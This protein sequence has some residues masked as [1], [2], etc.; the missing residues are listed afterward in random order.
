MSDADLGA[1][2]RMLAAPVIGAAAA[3]ETEAAL[4]KAETLERVGMIPA[5]VWART[6]G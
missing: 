6:A 5:P 2:F 3:G 1:K 4:W